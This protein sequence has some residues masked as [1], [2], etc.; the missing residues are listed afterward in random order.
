METIDNTKRL[1]KLIV[2][3]FLSI[4]FYGLLLFL[5][6]NNKAYIPVKLV[7]TD[8]YIPLYFWLVVVA[9]SGI[10]SYFNNIKFSKLIPNML[11][12]GAFLHIYLM[13]L[14][15]N[16][17]LILKIDYSRIYLC[18]AF[19]V[20][21]AM[22][23]ISS[24]FMFKILLANKY[25]NGN[26]V[27]SIEVLK[28]EMY[29]CIPLA[30]NG[31]YT[32]YRDISFVN[33]IYFS[34]HLFIL[35]IV[36]LKANDKLNLN[37]S[38][39]E[40][41][42]EFFKNETN[43][44]ITIFLFSFFVRVFFAFHIIGVTGDR[45]P[46]A[47]D[48][49]PTYDDYGV[50]IMQNISNLIYG[51]KI[52]PGAYDPG[53][54]M[55]M[56]GVYKIFGQNFYAAS[57]IQSFLGGLM[58]VSIY[59]IAKDILNKNIG[60]VAA[61]FAAIN[62]PLIM[63]SVV[64]ITESIYV[65]L[66]VISIY[67]LHKYTKVENIK[68]KKYFLLIAG[69]LMGF[70]IIS[71]AMLLLFPLF[72]AGWIL[73]QERRF[74]RV[75]F[76]MIFFAGLIP[77]LFLVTILTYT[78]TGEL[79]IFTSKQTTNWIAFTSENDPRR[80]YSNVRLIEMGVN[81]FED[82]K[83]SVLNILKD[84]LRFLAAEAQILPIRLKLFLFWPDYGFFDPV[85]ILTSTTPNQYASTIEFYAVLIIMIGVINVFIR[86][87]LICKASLV[88]LIIVYYLIIHVGLTTGQ[89]ERYRVPIN[90]FLIIFAAYGLSFFYKRVID[91]SSITWSKK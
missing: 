45:F 10:Y 48:D 85:Y 59:L 89:C 55:F 61:L 8:M 11:L 72:V 67:C 88:I 83:G 53:Y 30:I 29:L 28:K 66:L 27:P 3:F 43:V 81:P 68:N 42:I 34:F 37:S 40:K 84:P 87:K 39:K 24:Y 73:F 36:Y 9:Y 91:C 47:S 51:N 75:K 70:A 4:I 33:I 23:A 56:G 1:Q 58:P 71:R 64:L 35:Y 44:M 6:Q 41:I 82:L 86:K 76:I 32:F 46:T 90:P 38:V 63:L 78:N 19:I 31:F 14:S 52:M 12:L 7:Y 13:L 74:N 20:E 54:P 21:T 69:F 79:R 17:F 16:Q 57:L 50:L 25:F 80:I 18:Y 65:P 15:L 2:P 49:G 62:Q 77:A 26:V 60:V 5:I 22:F